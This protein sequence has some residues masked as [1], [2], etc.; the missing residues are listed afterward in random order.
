[1]RRRLRSI[2]L[3]GR[4]LGTSGRSSAEPL[5]SLTWRPEGLPVPPRAAAPLS[6]PQEAASASAMEPWPGPT[7]PSSE[8]LAGLPAKL[9]GAVVAGDAAGQM[10]PV[11]AR[12]RRWRLPLAPLLAAAVAAAAE[13]PSA[14]LAEAR[15]CRTD[16]DLHT[17]LKLEAAKVAMGAL[18]QASTAW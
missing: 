10:L 7:R 3:G 13:G 1:M 18:E 17:V 14:S 4:S 8:D 2:D 6:S 16:G 12:R 11:E 9:A 15:R 5:Q